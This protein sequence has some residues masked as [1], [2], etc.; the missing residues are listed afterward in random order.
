MRK[1]YFAGILQLVTIGHSLCQRPVRAQAQLHFERQASSQLD[2][3]VDRTHGPLKWSHGGYLYLNFP[4]GN[5][6]PTI[7]TLDR[8]GQLISQFT[9][10]VPEAERYWVPDWDRQEDGTIALVGGV[11]SASGKQ[12]PLLA[13]VPLNGASVRLIRTAPYRPYML[14]IAPDGTLWT[15]G[16][17]FSKN[18]PTDPARTSSAG[19]LRHFDAAGR[20]LASAGPQSDYLQNGSALEDGLQSGFLVAQRDRVGWY[21][22]RNQLGPPRL[23]E[24]SLPSMQPHAYAGVKLPDGNPRTMA[25]GFAL[26]DSLNAFLCIQQPSAHA[27]TTYTLDR[28]SDTWAPI[29]VPLEAGSK[30]SPELIGSDGEEIVFYDAQVKNVVRYRI[31]AG[32]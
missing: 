13:I 7:Y 27:R 3:I 11:W 23:V 17:E 4:G 20:L 26:T 12:S 14:S 30:R 16:F 2:P 22:P 32:R 18:D 31:S 9:L 19:I 6:P 8:G 28:P 10:H 21:S 29:S 15:L 24:I 25:F 1:L 5:L